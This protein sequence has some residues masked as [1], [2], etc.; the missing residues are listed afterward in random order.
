VRSDRQTLVLFDI[1]GTLIQSGRAGLRGMTAA[2]RRLHGRDNALAGVPFAGRTDRAIVA[3]VLVR[4]GVEPSDEHLTRLRE[5]Y[6]DDLR[7]EIGRPVEAPSGVLPGVL[8]LL[9]ALDDL[10]HVAVGLLTGNF[11]GG[12]AI[13]LGHFGLW[14]RFRFGAYGDDHTDRRALVP[15]ALERA[16]RAGV[17]VPPLERVTVVGDTPLDVDCAR[18]HGA[19]AFGVA[20]GPFGRDELVAAGAHRVAPTLADTTAIVTWL[21]SEG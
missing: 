8:D 11:E 7:T 16:A 1:D 21:A 13:K 4:L 12:A 9:A 10:P 5:A 14:E 2:F 15:V 19:R 6:L 3:D 17:P 20:T 18:A